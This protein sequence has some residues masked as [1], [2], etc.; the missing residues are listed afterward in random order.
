MCATIITRI[1]YF[2]FVNVNEY[3]EIC[4][5]AAKSHIFHNM[6]MI[7]RT[8]NRDLGKHATKLLK[9]IRWW[10]HCT[11]LWM[12]KGCISF[13][14]AA[15]Q[16]IT[17]AAVGGFDG[18]ALDFSATS[19]FF[20]LYAYSSKKRTDARIVWFISCLLFISFLLWRFMTRNFFVARKGICFFP[21]Q[22]CNF[23]NFTIFS[24][25]VLDFSSW[26]RNFKK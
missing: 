6:Q 9:D 10:L 2:I 16:Q 13:V 15:L 3:I 20:E 25:F 26:G 23:N 4:S 24:R 5:R 12:R 8:E 17:H 21:M 19:V 7:T 14:K 11:V 18:L 1:L 22:G